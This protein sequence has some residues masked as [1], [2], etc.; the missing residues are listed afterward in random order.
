MD[1]FQARVRQP[2]LVR[3]IELLPTEV[4]IY[5]VGGAIREL[6]TCRFFNF[7]GYGSD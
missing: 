3:I 7:S 1:E 2:L 4:P 5:L 6:Y